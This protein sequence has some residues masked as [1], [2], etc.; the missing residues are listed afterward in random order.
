MNKIFKII[1]QQANLG[2][3]KNC[4]EKHPRNAQD[5]CYDCIANYGNLLDW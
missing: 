4:D 1:K 3:C 5:F 2:K